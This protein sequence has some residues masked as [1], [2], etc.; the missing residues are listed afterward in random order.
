MSDGAYAL[1]ALGQRKFDEHVRIYGD[2]T[3]SVVRH[4]FDFQVAIASQAIV[5][6]RPQPLPWYWRPVPPEGEV[7]LSQAYDAIDF[8]ADI[9]A[10]EVFKVLARP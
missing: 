9:S 7:G 3:L 6:G 4:F 1:S 10:H 2:P 5:A 8:A